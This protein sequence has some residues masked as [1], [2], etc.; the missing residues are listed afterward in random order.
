MIGVCPYCNSRYAK[1]SGD[2]VHDCRSGASE[3]LRNEDVVVIGDWEDYTGSGTV[4]K[5][6]VLLQAVQNELA[7]TRAG[8]DGDNFEGVTSRGA[9]KF[10]HRSRAHLEYIK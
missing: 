9:R 2:F 8:L 7:G 1:M 6:E 10:T 4:N 3:A 5:G